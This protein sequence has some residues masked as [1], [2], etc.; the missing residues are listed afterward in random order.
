M[1][2]R[3]ITYN[4][5]IHNHLGAVVIDYFLECKEAAVISLSINTPDFTEIFQIY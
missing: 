3:K 5:Y 4:A 2:I 1:I